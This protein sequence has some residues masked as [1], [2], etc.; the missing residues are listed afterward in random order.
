MKKA[1]LFTI[2]LCLFITLVGCIV[3]N[4]QPTDDSLLSADTEKDIQE[5]SEVDEETSGVD[6][7]TSEVDQE[8]SH[9][10]HNIDPNDIETVIHYDYYYVNLEEALPLC[11]DIVVAEYIGKKN[12]ERDT[13]NEFVIKKRILGEHVSDTIFVNNRIL[14]VHITATSTSYISDAPDYIVGEQYVLILER[15]VSVYYETDRYLPVTLLYLP[16]NDLSKSTICGEDIN[17]Y[18]TEIKFTKDLTVSQL[19]DYLTAATKDNKKPFTGRPYIKSDK[20]EDVVEGSEY[21][22]KIEV[23]KNVTSSM[24]INRAVYECTVKKVYK[25]ELEV[26]IAVRIFFLPGTVEEGC[27]Y[28]VAVEESEGTNKEGFVLSS[29][30]S[31]FTVKQEA[32]IVSKLK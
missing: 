18:T 19:L 4:E 20:L 1:L 31:I 3:N 30:N 7:E 25:G 23:G 13:I 5:T 27:K 22:I 10:N 8:T 17:K 11:T 28:I 21:I 24:T 16:A 29:K 14:E 6:E 9:D 15:S 12:T 2:L 32:L 26:D